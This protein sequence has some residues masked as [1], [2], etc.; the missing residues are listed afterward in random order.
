M[1]LPR[2]DW[3]SWD[4]RCT[5]HPANHT[6]SSCAS[7]SYCWRRQICE[8]WFACPWALDV[9]FF[10]L[11]LLQEID[12]SLELGIIF[13]I[14]LA[15]FESRVSNSIWCRTWILRSPI[16]PYQLPNQCLPTIADQSRMRWSWYHFSAERYFPRT[17]IWLLR[18]R[19]KFEFLCFGNRSRVR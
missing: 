5:V 14:P 19:F 17:E 7:E 11:G 18:P 12:L 13:M 6:S 1:F 4:C 10:V 9:F 3:T 8:T 15:I 16:L 2:P